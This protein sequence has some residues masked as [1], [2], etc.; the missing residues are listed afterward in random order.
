MSTRLPASN[1]LAY[2]GLK[3]TNP[4]QLYFRTRSPLVTD[5]RSYDMGDIWIDQ[6]ALEGWILAL[7]IGGVA[8]WV[9]M[10]GTGANESLTGDIGGAVFPD[11]A[12]NI[13]FLGAGGLTVTGVPAANTL[14]VAPSGGGSLVESL[15]GDAGLAV[16]PDG[17]GNIDVLGNSGAYLNGILFTGDPANNTLTGMDLRNVT[18]YVVDA[19][20]GQTEYQTVQAAVTAANAAGGGLVYVREGTF[21]EDLVLYDNIMI[22][23]MGLET[24]ITGV[25]L[26]P[27]AGTLTLYDLT[28][29]SPTDILESA[30]AGTTLILFFDCLINCDNGYTCDLLNWTG[31]VDMVQC[32]ETSTLNGI[33]NNTGGAALNIWNSF[34]GAGATDLVLD[35]G[36]LAIYDSRIIN[37]IVIGG[38]TVMTAIMGCSFAATISL[39]D[40]SS[41]E[42]YNSM[43]AVGDVPCIAQNS[44]GTILLS[45]V[46]L[47]SPNDPV[48][49]GM[50][51]GAI[52]VASVT[53][54][55][56]SNIAGALTLVHTTAHETGVGFMQNISFD[57][58][59]TQIV[60][61]GELIIGD[62][63]NVPQIN[64]LT[65]GAGIAIANGAGTI[66][67]AGTA[68][69]ALLFT[70]DVGTATPALNNLNIVGGA[71]I[72][73]AGAGST[74]TITATG[75]GMAWVDATNAAYNLAVA[76]AYGSNRGGGVAFTLPAVAAQGTIIEIIGILGLWNIVQGGGQS[77]EVGMFT[78]TVGAGGSL[79]ATNVGDCVSLRCITADTVFRVENMMGNP[80]IV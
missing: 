15:T 54:V 3:E 32:A 16:G 46:S 65:A 50:G 5:S 80:A 48:I 27:T 42:M 70:E 35:D 64:T 8:N 68:T 34:A 22:Q 57:R 19:V 7:N 40:T 55:D 30:A 24:I 72:A 67:I 73:T 11:G 12:D 45:D 14:T 6:T 37:P 26:P 28:L 66:T 77:V 13:N 62:T 74:V 75:S 1:P 17:V 31:T 53:Y 10:A 56:I 25:H 39:D 51:A 58:G 41:L 59:T 33:F 4:P 52:T 2:V 47:N 20:A 76:T 38:N 60:A 79:T 21:T 9:G 71:G 63:G 29:T 44:M 61:D 69:V 18:T 78:T 49:D 43:S 36:V 23:G